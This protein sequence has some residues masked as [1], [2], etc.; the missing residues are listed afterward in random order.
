[1]TTLEA[2]DELTSDATVVNNDDFAQETRR[3][4]LHDRVQ[5]LHDLE[6]VFMRVKARDDRR[7]RQ[8][9]YV[10]VLFVLAPTTIDQTP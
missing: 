2:G 5:R 10:S 3:R 7:L 6:K 9:R 8:D 1:M 4:A